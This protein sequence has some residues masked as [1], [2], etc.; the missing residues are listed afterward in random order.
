MDDKTLQC[1]LEVHSGDG[2]CTR[3]TFTVKH[4]PRTLREV[5][6]LLKAQDLRLQ[7][8]NFE[9]SVICGESS[10]PQQLLADRDVNN[11]FSSFASERLLF[12]VTLQERVGGLVSSM[13]ADDSLVH[14]RIYHRGND[15]VT[16]KRF[17]PPRRGVREALVIAVRDA[18]QQPP[19]AS[20]GM[21]LYAIVGDMC[22]Q[23]A[24]K[25]EDAINTFLR[26]CMVTRSVCRLTYQFDNEGVISEAD[27]FI[28]TKKLGVNNAQL[29]P[30]DPIQ[31]NSAT[32]QMPKRNDGDDVLCEKPSRAEDESDAPCEKPS[33]VEDESDAPCEKPS[34]VEDESD[35]PCEKPSRA[36][37]ESQC[38]PAKKPSRV[39]DES[40]AQASSVVPVN[41][42]NSALVSKSSSHNGSAA[43]EPLTQ[44]DAVSDPPETAVSAARSASPL[45]ELAKNGRQLLDG[46]G[47]LKQNDGDPPAV[48][49]TAKYEEAPRPIM[50]VAEEKVPTVAASGRCHAMDAKIKKEKLRIEIECKFG[51][52]NVV[53]P[54]SWRRDSASVLQSLRE[55][56]LIAL[57]VPRGENVNLYDR[58]GTVLHT[59]EDTCKRLESILLSGC[60][61]IGLVLWSGHPCTSGL[62]L[63]C[64]V[65]W[66]TQQ[67]VM[68]C[69]VE[70]EMALMDL[71][72][73]ILDEYGMD[74]S[75]IDGLHLFLS[76]GE[77]EAESELTSSRAYEQLKAA[78][79]HEEL[80]NIR[81]SIRDG[82]SL[83][84]PW[85]GICPLKP[86]RL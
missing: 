8:G 85:R 78:S 64:C 62:P 74:Y 27:A 29:P 50:L 16:E 41:D 20:V 1:T 65:S 37:D 60:T 80:V 57:E 17:I 43:S 11:L 63:Q 39:E 55:A 36:E 13:L 23:T 45:R 12:K 70:R 69:T 52:S 33:R 25:D 3:R 2:E 47:H 83:C 48:T 58:K 5:V 4:L 35:A 67:I 71:R 19:P 79:L 66:G 31:A 7:R 28:Q 40:D 72:R 26:S 51:D 34:R 21:Q 9:F 84:C 46:A 59:E 42:V 73:A 14:L 24:L 54:F 77:M 75:N 86:R 38:S 32:P 76:N 10:S 61:R 49:L 18:I 81:V 53:F 15:L 68:V 30:S 44:M 56:C 22:D 82:P 6:E